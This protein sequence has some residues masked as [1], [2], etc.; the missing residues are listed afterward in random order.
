M[1]IRISAE[2]IKKLREKTGGG[3]ADVKKALEESRGDVQRAEEL[4]LRKLG[5]TASKKAERATFAG[6]VDSYIHT[7]GKIGTLV[8]LH[9][10]TDFVARNPLFKEL[11]HDIAMHVAAMSPLYVSLEA[12]PSEEWNKEKA[13]FEE[14][15]RVM[16]KPP[17]IAAEVVDG[18]L[19][20]HFAALSLLSQPFVKDQDRTVQDV[21]SEAAGKF[22]EN[23]KI[24]AFMRFEI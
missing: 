7:S 9:C 20:S 10:E 21:L 22:G 14:E 23:L 16:Q 11:A 8:E 19:K 24:G 3:I 17:H 4:I 15:V 13:R 18:K 5:M 2:L 6:I 1:S 12:V